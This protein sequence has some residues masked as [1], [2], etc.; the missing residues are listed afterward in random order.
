MIKNSK[1]KPVVI[2]KPANPKNTA[3]KVFK[4]SKKRYKHISDLV[5]QVLAR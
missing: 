1:Q 2:N 5:D 3:F 4:I